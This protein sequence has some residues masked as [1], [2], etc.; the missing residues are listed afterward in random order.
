MNDPKKYDVS[1]ETKGREKELSGWEQQS[2]AVADW[3]DARLGV[4]FWM[5]AGLLFVSL[6]A[7]TPHILVTYQCYGRCGDNATELNC[8]YLGIRGW[9]A[10]DPERDKC[11]RLR[12][13]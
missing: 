6:F 10:A 13:M 12:L 9:K 2:Y 5:L 8:Q 3:L 4:R 7:G 1:V 11:P